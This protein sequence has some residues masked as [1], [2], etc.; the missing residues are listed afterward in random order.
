[1]RWQDY[2]FT[3]VSL[4]FCVTLVP[5]IRAQTKPPLISSVPITLGLYVFVGL[6][7]TL[8]FVLA[9]TVD[10]VQGSLWAWLGWQRWSDDRRNRKYVDTMNKPLPEAFEHWPGL[11]VIRDP[12]VPRGKA[13]LI[14]RGFLTP[15]PKLKFGGDDD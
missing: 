9:P 10:F 12:H 11:R 8:H 5:M 2:V 7:L 3:F 15:D 13:F 6:Y 4:V 1:M 14:D